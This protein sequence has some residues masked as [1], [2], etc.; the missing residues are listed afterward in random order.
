MKMTYLTLALLICP[1]LWSPPAVAQEAMDF[2]TGGDEEPAATSPDAMLG[3][4][5]NQHELARTHKAIGRMPADE[6]RGLFEQAIEQYE[7][8]SET[9]PNDA[10]AATA[11]LAKAR[12]QRD[13]GDDAAALIT[14]SKLRDQEPAVAERTDAALCA[15]YTSKALVEAVQA[16]GGSKRPSDA[17]RAEAVDRGRTI[18]LPDPVAKQV[19]A[20]R[21]FARDSEGLTPDPEV[22]SRV[23]YL[24]ADLL[25]AYGRKDEAAPLF[26]KVFRWRPAADVASAAAEELLQGPRARGDWDA[27]LAVIERLRQVELATPAAT[28]DFRSKLAQSASNAGF[29]R[30]MKL[31]QAE[32]WADAE[33]ELAALIAADPKGADTARALFNR[34]YCLRKLGRDDEAL[35]AYRG[36]IEGWPKSEMLP[37]AL[38]MAGQI[39]NEKRLVDDAIALWTRFAKSYPKDEDAP[40]ALLSAADLLLQDNRLPEAAELLDL[41]VKQYGDK[42]TTLLARTGDLYGTMGKA[43]EALDRYERFLKSGEGEPGERVRVAFQAGLQA[44]RLKKASV[45]RKHFEGAARMADDLGV[46]GEWADRARAK[47]RAEKR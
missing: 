10:R 41:H 17:Q 19:E 12:A 23:V 37:K 13:T 3:E 28:A 46:Q 1:L 26:E 27:Y 31:L 43:K 42:R 39:A 6:L 30:V 24:L 9:F 18:P 7:R 15:V 47:T 11:K 16:Q 29:A 21:Y 20:M 8:F 44:E 35:A 45:A 34:G 2:T 40:A 36:V 4:A 25:A 22:R 38:L 14:C 32:R 33:A 5:T